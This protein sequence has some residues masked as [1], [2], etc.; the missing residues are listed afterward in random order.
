MEEIEAEWLQSP[1]LVVDFLYGICILF[2]IVTNPLT[3]FICIRSNLR[4]TPTYIF[5]SFGAIST[6]IS[7]FSSPL[8]YFLER[9]VLDFNPRNESLIWCK[10]QYFLTFYMIHCT[11]WF[12]VSFFKYKWLFE[13]I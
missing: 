4:K 1:N 8:T 11:V 3:I 5:I 12:L 6:F 10:I 9:F 7:L 2:G 13:R